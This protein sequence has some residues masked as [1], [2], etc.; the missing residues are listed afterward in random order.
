MYIRRCYGKNGNSYTYIN[1]IKSIYTDSSSTESL[2]VSLTKT[3]KTKTKAK[4]IRQSARYCARLLLVAIYA[5]MLQYIASYSI[6][7]INSCNTLSAVS[8]YTQSSG[9]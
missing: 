9:I 6:N 7:N 8:Q 2:N 3:L 5:C 1:S 4:M